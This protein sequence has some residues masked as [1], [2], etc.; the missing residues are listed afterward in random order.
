LYNLKNDIGESMDLAQSQPEK[1]R[2]LQSAWDRW[3]AGNVA[4]LW[5]AEG[6]LPK[7]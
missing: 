1:V 6:K 3:N 2:E 7:N 5:A 4:P